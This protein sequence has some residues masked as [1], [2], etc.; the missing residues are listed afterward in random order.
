LE[1]FLVLILSNVHCTYGVGFME[2]LTDHE[3][4]ER[5]NFAAASSRL[6]IRSWV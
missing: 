5:P 3:L 4:A 1:T 6:M 2:E